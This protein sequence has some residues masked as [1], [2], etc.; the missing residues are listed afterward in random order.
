M[1][2]EI[3]NIMKNSLFNSPPPLPQGISLSQDLCEAS[4]GAPCF[5]RLPWGPRGPQWRW[6]GPV[7]IGG[8]MGTHSGPT[9]LSGCLSHLVVNGQ[10]CVW[11][12][13]MWHSLHVVHRPYICNFIS[14]IC[15]KCQYYSLMVLNAH[16]YPFFT[17]PL[18]SCETWATPS[19]PRAPYPAAAEAPP[20]AAEAPGGAA[21]L[22]RPGTPYAGPR[23]PLRPPAP[24]G[25]PAPLSVSGP[26]MC[27]FCLLL[28][29]VR[30]GSSL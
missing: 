2:V 12:V 21:A 17:P 28:L 22:R 27:S 8:L 5:L 9:G 25:D 26:K 3:L 11:T 15:F 29:A 19:S 10:V 4:P 30:E 16:P 13:K 14:S 24:R 23:A 1:N 18:P 20:A 7:S 6:Q